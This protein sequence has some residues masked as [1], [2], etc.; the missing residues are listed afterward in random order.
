ML[1]KD[2]TSTVDTVFGEK[3]VELLNTLQSTAWCVDNRIL[4]VAEHLNEK[5]IQ[6]GKF[7]VCPFDKPEKGNAP[8]RIVEDEELFKEWKR[9]RSY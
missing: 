6:V 3:T 5:I 4:E 1:L 2:S 7:K 9:H 8:E